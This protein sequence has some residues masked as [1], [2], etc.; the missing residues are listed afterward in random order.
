MPLHAHRQPHACAYIREALSVT[1]PLWCL[2]TFRRQPSRLQL[3]APPWQPESTAPWE[4][5]EQGAALRA[6]QPTSSVPVVS[7]PSSYPP[8]TLTHTY[9]HT[10]AR[11][12][13][14]HAHTA[15]TSLD[16]HTQTRD[17]RARTYRDIRARRETHT[18]TQTLTHTHTHTHTLSHSPA[19]CVSVHAL[20]CI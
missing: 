4:M 19:L 8:H 7:T 12:G 13:E 9:T 5:S 16:K 3:P 11:T 15:E 2:Q 1:D 18:H 17:I 10:Q 6:K 14:A 20:I